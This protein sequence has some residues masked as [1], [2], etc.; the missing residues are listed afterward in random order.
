ME[1]ED[2]DSILIKRKYYLEYLLNFLNG[3]LAS[4]FLDDISDNKN[5]SVDDNGVRCNINSEFKIEETS[6]I[7][8]LKFNQACYDSDIENRDKDYNIVLLTVKSSNKLSLY[9]SFIYGLNLMICFGHDYNC[10]YEKENSP[11]IYELL[12]HGKHWE[13]FRNIIQN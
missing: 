13:K 6:D 1:N 2:K 7:I 8:L 5:K 10:C 3:E 4:N 11:T 9:E 12:K